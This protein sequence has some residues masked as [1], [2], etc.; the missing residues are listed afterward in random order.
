MPTLIAWLLFLLGVG[1]IG[2]G[3]II[4]KTPLSDALADGFFGKFKQT[5]ARLA[6]FWFMIFGPLLMLAGHSAIHAV[7]ISDLALI[8]L[9]GAYGLVISLIGIAAF[10]K[11]PFLVSGVLALLLL[12]VS[13]G[14]M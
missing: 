11:S 1:H 3:L 6:A 14:W 4:C 2:Y 8:K 5:D 12:A 10:P 7:A 13:Y 9:I